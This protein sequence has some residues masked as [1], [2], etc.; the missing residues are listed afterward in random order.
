[1]RIE[2]VKHNLNS[3]VG[4]NDVVPLSTGIEILRMI[5]L[6]ILFS[7]RERDKPE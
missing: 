4:S 7:L 3:F 5:E 2:P 1:M 6:S